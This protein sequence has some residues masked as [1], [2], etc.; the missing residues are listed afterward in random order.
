MT[1]ETQQL[2]LLLSACSGSWRNCVYI[3]TDGPGYLLSASRDGQPVVMAVETF[4]QLSGAD[5]A[6]L[7]GARP[8]EVGVWISRAAQ[9]IRREIA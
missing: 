9:K 6:R 2:Y 1:T 7:Y 4:R 3:S 5:I 8:N